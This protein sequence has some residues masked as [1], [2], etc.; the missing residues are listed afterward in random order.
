ML[1]WTANIA[2]AERMPNLFEHFRGASYY[3]VNIVNWALE[4][5]KSDILNIIDEYLISFLILNWRT[6]TFKKQYYE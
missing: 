5:Y 3:Y 4:K 1:H 6:F 2:K